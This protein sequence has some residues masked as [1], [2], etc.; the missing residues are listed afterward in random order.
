M[1]VPFQLERLEAELP[2]DLRSCLREARAS[3]LS[4][5]SP[6]PSDPAGESSA[7]PDCLRVVMREMADGELLSMGRSR[8]ASREF[9][10]RYRQHRASGIKVLGSLYAARLETPQLESRYEAALKFLADGVARRGEHRQD[11]GPGTA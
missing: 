8:L 2:P 4:C 5:W 10:G 3:M 9:W 7:E 11:A 1:M 6:E